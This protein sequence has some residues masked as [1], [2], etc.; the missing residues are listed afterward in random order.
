M[1]LALALLAMTML[2]MALLL[3]PLIL[4]RRTTASRDAYNLA[5][6]RDQLAEIERDVGRGVL[7]PG[8][9]E[10]AKAE[11]GR[12]ILALS[13]VEGRSAAS[14]S[15]LAV[16]IAAIVL[17]PFAALILYWDLGS[18]SLP[19]EPHDAVAASPHLDI[20]TALKQLEAHLA[21]NPDDLKGWLL[22]ARTDLD[23]G[24]YIDAA[25]AYRHAAELSN[26]R[27]VIVGDWGEAQVMAAGGTVTPEAVAAFKTAL[28]DPE[29]APRSRINQALADFQAG[30][31]K[32]ERQEWVDLEAASPD[33]AAWLPMLRKR[34]AEAAK[35]L[36]VDPASLK[37]SSGAPRK[38]AAQ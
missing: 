13:P 25:E 15:R 1:G 37:T 3:G 36:G 23:L 32:K 27:P 18:P 8:D 9:A 4:R 2:A 16:A 34:I 14:R 29:A 28:A 12:R 19:D 10:A 26:Q 35:S 11:I 21:D 24:R 7:D 22:L 30:D 31:T 20:A 38:A 6:Y 17:V 5:V 33:D